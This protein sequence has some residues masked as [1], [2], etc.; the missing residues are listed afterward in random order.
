MLSKL[1]GIPE[2]FNT[3]CR[4]W[5]NARGPKLNLMSSKQVSILHTSRIINILDLTFPE[6]IPWTHTFSERF[7]HLKKHFQKYYFKMKRFKIWNL[8]NS[9]HILFIFGFYARFKNKI[10]T[11][12]ST[13]LNVVETDE[14]RNF[15]VKYAFWIDPY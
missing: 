7:N 3:N 14:F 12:I 6:L 2:L 5:E 8:L 4:Y 15:N 1:K 10:A 11:N 13:K 9:R